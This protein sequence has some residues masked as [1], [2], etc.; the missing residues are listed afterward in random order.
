[1]SRETEIDAFVAL[2]AEHPGLG[3]GVGL[4]QFEKRAVEVVE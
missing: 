2:L 1:M 3:R 4:K